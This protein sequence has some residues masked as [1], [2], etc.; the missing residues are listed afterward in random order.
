MIIASCYFVVK[1]GIT[2]V[3]FSSFG[4]VV[5]RL[6]SCFFLGVVSLLVLE[7]FSF[8][9]PLWDWICGKILFKFGSVLENFGF[10]I[11]GNCEFLLGITAWTFIFVLL[12]SV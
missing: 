1:V 7:D 2:F 8:S 12:E 9:Y 6:L 3:S 10:F 5:K 4:F 11:Y